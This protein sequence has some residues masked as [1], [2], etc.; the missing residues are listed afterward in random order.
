MWGLINFS[1][2]YANTLSTR[3][4]GDATYAT[5]DKLDK[6]LPFGPIL[7]NGAVLPAGFLSVAYHGALSLLASALVLKG[8]A[9][10]MSWLA[11]MVFSICWTIGV[12]VPLTHW[13][14]NTQTIFTN[15][16]VGWMTAGS[17]AGYGV[18]DHAGAHHI[19]MAAGASAMV[20]AFCMGTLKKAPAA[21]GD[22][23]DRGV[24]WTLFGFTG[25]LV[26]GDPNSGS[27]GNGPTLV[28][29]FMSVA[30]AVLT[31]TTLDVL[32]NRK[33][34][35]SA[36][37]VIRGVTYGLIA[38]TA[39]G[40]LISPMWAA[41]FGFATV[42]LVTIVDRLIGAAGLVG[43]GQDSVFCVH[44][45]GAAISSALTG[46]WTNPTYSGGVI[47]GSF[48]GNSAQLGRQCGGI[49]VVLLEASVATA[50][51]YGFVY[52]IS[53]AANTPIHSP[54]EEKKD[55][56]LTIASVA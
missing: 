55:A 36:E 45:L 18:L 42:L 40:S 29:I 11:M 32:V 23:A 44:F 6:Q 24:F 14:A 51:I 33:A 3:V 37:G 19:H 56:A 10:D 49:A 7:F 15:A 52:A 38:M 47:A 48:Y 16:N 39:G 31:T 50:V 8:G 25:Y 1:I 26:M 53:I 22:F 41:F 30:T 35:P 28:N 43:L 2:C 54:A 4:I 13:Q 21:L 5:I 17:T 46:L 34:T 9:G 12:Y 27:G 20:L